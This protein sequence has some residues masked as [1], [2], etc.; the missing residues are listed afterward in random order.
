M[1]DSICVIEEPGQGYDQLFGQFTAGAFADRTNRLDDN[2][3][4]RDSNVATPDASLFLPIVDNNKANRISSGFGYQRL[5]KQTNPVLDQINTNTF[6]DTITNLEA[7]DIKIKDEDRKSELVSEKANQNTQFTRLA[8]AVSRRD[9]N[10]S[11]TL[12]LSNGTM[13]IEN[14]A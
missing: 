10:N 12:L 3:D 5:D 4:K 1:D 2:V 7:F 8:D 14:S 11:R 6:L 9:H 13:S